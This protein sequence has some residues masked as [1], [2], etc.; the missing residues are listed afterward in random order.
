MAWGFNQL[1]DGTTQFDWATRG[2]L[3]GKQTNDLLADF[4]AAGLWQRL[5]DTT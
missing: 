3:V 1:A 4:G 2:A 5:N